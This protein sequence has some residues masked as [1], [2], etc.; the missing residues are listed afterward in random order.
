MRRCAQQS[1]I[2]MAVG[3]S[4]SSGWNVWNYGADT[5]QGSIFVGTGEICSSCLSQWWE[6]Y[7]W[8]MS[9]IELRVCGQANRW[10]C[11][12]QQASRSIIETQGDS[13]EGGVGVTAVMAWELNGDSKLLSMETRDHSQGKWLLSFRTLQSPTIA[14]MTAWEDLWISLLY[15]HKFLFFL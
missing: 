2:T 15:T 14:K 7:T 4:C 8:L 12:G 9:R 13:T 3:S 10:A 5:K 6:S 1:V 11:R